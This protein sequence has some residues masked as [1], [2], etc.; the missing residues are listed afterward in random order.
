[1]DAKV[2]RAAAASRATEI[3]ALCA[4]AKCPELAA[5]YIAGS[6]ALD[7]VRAHLTT[8]TAKLDRVEIDANLDPD[9][10]LKKGSA[11]DVMGSY[12]ALGQKRH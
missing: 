6:I 9:H 12:A 4:T 2:I 7:A 11:V 5:G 10:G 8:I 1:M 3:T